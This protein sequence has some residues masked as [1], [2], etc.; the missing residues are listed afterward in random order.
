MHSFRQETGALLACPTLRLSP[1]RPLWRGLSQ[2]PPRS[3]LLGNQNAGCLGTTSSVLRTTSAHVPGR[4]RS[5]PTPA[6]WSISGK[7]CWM[8]PSAGSRTSKSWKMAG[9]PKVRRPK[10]QLFPARSS[11]E[12]CESRGGLQWCT[13][14]M[15]MLSEPGPTSGVW[16]TALFAALGLWSAPQTVHDVRLLA[17]LER[18]PPHRCCC[19]NDLGPKRNRTQLLKPFHENERQSARWPHRCCPSSPSGSRLDQWSQEACVGLLPGNA[20]EGSG[21]A[22]SNFEDTFGRTLVPTVSGLFLVCVE[23]GCSPD[24][25]IQPFPLPKER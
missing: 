2:G 1:H 17:S 15:G 4:E 21:K 16:P 12:S 25:P 9:H 6:S 7:G 23:T 13:S 14:Q 3:R 10:E 19:G 20:L 22:V 18:Q 8:Q 24:G 5:A 11:Q